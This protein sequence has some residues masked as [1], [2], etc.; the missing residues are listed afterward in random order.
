MALFI[1]TQLR[2]QNGWKYAIKNFVL[3]AND[4]SSSPFATFILN[5]LK[6]FLDFGSVR[7]HIFCAITQI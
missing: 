7:V 4:R 1:L 5:D 6:I 3:Q 2:C